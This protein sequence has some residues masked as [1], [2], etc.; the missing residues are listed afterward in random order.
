MAEKL[1]LV[2]VEWLPSYGTEIAQLKARTQRGARA[3]VA[4]LLD[5]ET[6]VGPKVPEGYTVMNDGELYMLKKAIEKALGIYAVISWAPEDV[7]ERKKISLKKAR[8]WLEENEKHVA[9]ASVRGGW[10]AI[11]TL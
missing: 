4:R 9:E 7:K 2:P 1:F 5:R 11:E 3:E 10:D 8:E 6:T